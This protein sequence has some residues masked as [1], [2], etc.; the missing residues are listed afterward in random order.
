MQKKKKNNFYKLK[1]TYALITGAAGLLGEQHAISLLDIGLNII[2]TDINENKIL[3][4]KKKLKKEYKNSNIIEYKMDVTDENSIKYLIKLL[5]KK[6]YFVKILINNAAIDSKVKKGSKMNYCGSLEQTSL[7]DW[8][9]FI[10][11]NLTGAFLCSKFFGDQM[12]K[13]GGGVIINIASDLSLIAPNHSIYSKGN[14]KPI[15]YSVTKHGLIG[16]TK[17]L[18]TY[19][20][21]KNVRCNALSPGPVDFGQGK[22]FKEKLKKLIPLNRLAKKDEYKS[23]IQFL[24]TDASSYMTGQNMIIDGGRTVW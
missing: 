14:F 15:M 1:N 5:V 21:H 23:A 10:N 7:Q 24:A 17:Y 12:A 13:K 19:W 6:N 4:L 16:L 8:N 18:S 9:K 3:L 11:V 20:N 2:L 22:K